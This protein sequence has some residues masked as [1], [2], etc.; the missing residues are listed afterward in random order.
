MYVQ[1]DA[2]ERVKEREER[3]RNVAGMV[4]ISPN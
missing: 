2:E 4:C 3:K 1:Y